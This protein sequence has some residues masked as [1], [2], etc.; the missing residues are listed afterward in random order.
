MSKNEGYIHG[1]VNLSVELVNSETGDHSNTIKSMWR[2]VKHTLPQSG[3]VK[4]MYGSHFAKFIFRR[5]YLGDDMQDK[6]LA[7]FDA[8]RHMYERTICCQGQGCA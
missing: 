4:G 7:F 5:K 3:S 8:M 2:A 1:M 6:F